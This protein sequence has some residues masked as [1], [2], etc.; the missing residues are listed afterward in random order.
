MLHCGLSQNAA[1][2]RNRKKIYLEDLE[3]KV[4]TFEE[5]CTAQQEA[6]AKLQGENSFLKQQLA[7][8][9]AVLSKVANIDISQ[10]LP[11]GLAAP[12]AKPVGLTLF[13]LFAMFLVLSVPVLDP[14]AGASLSSL[15]TG[16]GSARGGVQRGMQ[17]VLLSMVG[18]TAFGKDCVSDYGP[19]TEDQHHQHHHQASDHDRNGAVD[20]MHMHMH[21]QDHH[22]E[23]PEGVGHNN[24]NTFAP[25]ADSA[26]G[27]AAVPI[28]AR[29]WTL[30]RVLACKWRG[31]W[32]Y[33]PCCQ[34]GF[35]HC[36]RRGHA[37]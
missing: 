29:S 13:A 7:K 31:L 32:G 20:H 4:A 30:G 11:E 12:A 28:S 2:Y 37:E 36:E 24:T 5:T 27:A 33:K 23:F 3:D 26:A 34:P 35:H 8:L 25:T 22:H 10:V 21:D 16:S 6:V 19:G 9:S 14:Q 1:N 18:P 15:G 17:R